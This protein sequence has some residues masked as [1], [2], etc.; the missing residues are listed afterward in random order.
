[1]DLLIIIF[2]RKN[3]IL[4]RDPVPLKCLSSPCH[5]TNQ[6]L[7][8]HF[9]AQY[10]NTNEMNTL[11]AAVL[12]S[13]SFMLIIRLNTVYCISCPDLSPISCMLPNINGNKAQLSPISFMLMYEL[14]LLFSCRLLLLYLPPNSPRFMV[15]ALEPPSTASHCSRA[16]SIFDNCM[17]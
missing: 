9:W 11:S 14:N 7:V 8:P 6:L 16:C 5:K 17:H 2:G 12:S 4:S 3:W 1:M 15:R 10:C 13:I